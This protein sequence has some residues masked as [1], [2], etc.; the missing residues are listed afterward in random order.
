MHHQQNPRRVMPNNTASSE[1]SR[2]NMVGEQSKDESTIQAGAHPDSGKEEQ[3]SRQ[4]EH[5]HSYRVLAPNERKR[6][7]LIQQRERNMQYYEEVK[8]N[9]RMKYD[10]E[11]PR[12]IGGFKVSHDEVLEKRLKDQRR[13]EALE[14]RK[15]YEQKKKREKWAAEKKSVE[16]KEILEK[17]L[18]ARAQ[19]ERNEEKRKQEEI[20][21]KQRYD[22]DRRRRWRDFEYDNMRRKE[23]QVYIFDDTTEEESNPSVDE[24]RDLYVRRYGSGQSQSGQTEERYSSSDRIRLSSFHHAPRR[25][26]TDTLQASSS[27]EYIDRFSNLTTEDDTSPPESEQEKDIRKLCQTFPCA[28]RELIEDLYAQTNNSFEN[29]W[30]ILSTS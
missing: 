17:K 26:T 20:A 19:A 18:K 24:R 8:A 25:R 7:E 11:G 30:A 22:D 2:R 4:P 10:S 15:S 3:Q 23:N 28:G 29:T 21:K 12:K 1:G 9:N 27:E 6:R 13:A 16:E 5:S 14:K